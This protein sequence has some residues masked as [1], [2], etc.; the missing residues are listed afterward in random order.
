MNCPSELR[1]RIAIQKRTQSPDGLGGFSESWITFASTWAKISPTSA[2][3]RFFSE[4]LEHNITHKIT[5]RY[6][7]GISPDMRIQFGT[8]IFKINGIINPEER[9]IWLDLLCEEGAGS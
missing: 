7:S 3:E 8:R 4:K 5:I 2:R 6:R 1:H 9:N